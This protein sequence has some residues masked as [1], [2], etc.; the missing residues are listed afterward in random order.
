MA[1]V[2]SIEIGGRFNAAQLQQALDAI[3]DDKL[4]VSVGIKKSELQKSLKDIKD[5]KL[6]VIVQFDPAQIQ[7]ALKDAMGEVSATIPVKVNSSRGG[8]GNAS[9]GSGG[10]SE[11]VLPII[12]ENDL[13]KAG[14]TISK[15]NN[16]LSETER[17]SA[18]IK[19]NA[20]TTT[21]I[22]GRWNDELQEYEQTSERITVNHAKQKELQEK[23]SIEEQKALAKQ[24]AARTKEL[25]ILQRRLGTLREGIKLQ[26][27]YS[28]R[29]VLQAAGLP[30]NATITRN[31]A[32]TPTAQSGTW[33]RYTVSVRNAA[34][35]F[36]TYQIAINQATGAVRVLNQGAF[37][38]NKALAAQGETLDRLIIKVAKWAALTTLVYMPI[39]A[40]KEALTTLKEVDSELVTIQKV[41]DLSE[42]Q[43]KSL[44]STVYGLASAYGR[45]ADELL[46]MTSTFARAGFQAQLEEMTELAALTQNVGD[47]TGEEASQ[48]II[49][50]NAAWKLNGNMD[51][52]M[53]I[54]DGMN[55]VTNHSANDFQ[56]LSQGIS[57]A[58][59]VFANA[60]ESAQTFT[61]ML[62]TVVASTQR[63]GSEV[64]RGLRT[65]AMNIRQIKG[66][67]DDGE[68]IDESTISDA[69]AALSSVGISV[70][71]N[72]QLRRVSDV[73]TDLA[74]KWN[75]LTTAEQSY[76]A[77]SLAGKRQA[78]VLIAL[79][80]N[81]DEY[82]KEMENFA[83][84][85]GSA[86][87]ENEI[88]LDSWDAKTKML[89]ATWTEFVGNL[90]DT[91][92]VKDGL[93]IAIKA[94]DVLNNSFVQT[95]LVVGVAAKAVDLLGGR[96]L[97]LDSI[98]TVLPFLGSVLSGEMTLGAALAGTTA[99][100]L[101]AVAA[102]AGAVALYDKL[103]VTLKE[104]KDVV[105][106]LASE[107]ERM[108]GRG[109][110]LQ[111]LISRESELTDIERR[112]LVYLQAEADAA[113][114][115]LDAERAT[116]VQMARNEF[117][118]F[119]YDTFNENGELTTVD[120]TKAEGEARRLQKA[121]HDLT[122][123]YNSGGLALDEYRVE[124]A[125]LVTAGEETYDWVNALETPLTEGEAAWSLWYGVIRGVYEALLNTDK[126][127]PQ[128][129]NDVDELS[130]KIERL[131]DRY[132]DLKAKTDP[133]TQAQTELN[134][135]GFISVDTFDR[136]AEAYPDI[137][138]SSTAL[139]NGYKVEDGALGNLISAQET[140]S[141]VLLYQ[142]RT[143]AMQFINARAGMAVATNASTK[144]I[145]DHIEALEVEARIA[146]EVNAKS[147]E[148]YNRYLAN[149]KLY[150]QARSLKE[151][152]T[153]AEQITALINS[154]SSK[155]SSS[156][157]SSSKN[158]VLNGINDYYDI[159]KHRIW[160]SE[161]R[162]G[163]DVSA[164]KYQRELKQQA[165]YYVGLKKWSHDEAEKLRKQGYA[166]ESDEIKKLQ[167]IWWEAENWLRDQAKQTAEERKKAIDDVLSTLKDNLDNDKNGLDAQIKKLEALI[168][169]QE[170]Y[171][172]TLT[173]V[174]KE[175]A[176]ID[177][178]LKSAKESYQYLDEATRKMLFNESDY[179]VL[180]AKLTDISNEA[181]AIYENYQASINA[182]TEDNIYLA[183]QLTHEFEQQ[184]EA[185][186]KEY[187]IAKAELAMAKAQTGLQNAQANRNTFMLVDGQ[188]QWVADPKAIKDALENYADA[189][190]EYNEAIK[191]AS[192]ERIKNELEDSKQNLAT[193][194]A[195]LE[196]QYEAIERA[197]KTITNSMTENAV[198]ISNVLLEIAQDATPELRR[199]IEAFALM[200]SQVTGESY[201]I[202]GGTTTTKRDPITVQSINGQAPAGLQV[203]DYVQTNG[204]LW[205]IV[206]PNT[207]GANYNPTTGYWSVKVNNSTKS[208]GSYDD[209]G[210]ALGKGLLLKDTAMAEGVIK[211]EVMRDVLNPTKNRLF[212]SFVANVSTLLNG[213][214]LRQA[215]FKGLGGMV[216]DHSITVNG[217]TVN[218]QAAERLAKAMK[219][220]MPLYS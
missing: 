174:E 107:Y 128:T 58:G 99:P 2:Y 51:S 101:A 116:Y 56:A 37:Q 41:T 133:V 88:Y 113:K 168:S 172:D 200:L 96:L 186:R 21:N 20:Y 205:K 98:G 73:L 118:S 201:S 65:I 10:D 111:D 18:K 211:P 40:F 35:A 204:G 87:R 3:K 160:L 146:A 143:V 110:E 178:E 127:V 114:A 97:A 161:Q 162:M 210:V 91:R 123:Q 196:A 74:D 30:S 155:T 191:D 39:R 140:E 68:I 86:M 194:K 125:K 63:S 141:N 53:S 44:T 17:I 112:R 132:T 119:G 19:E 55:E 52:L 34:G 203:G 215:T 105:T 93:D 82:Y 36:D 104:Q 182:L 45:T 6:P 83:N 206:E 12:N 27:G 183:E 129:G 188:F 181:G 77:S 109:S 61:A 46:E 151:M 218:G 11:K 92:L 49:A 89:K 69:A 67:L 42:A 122:T 152:L 90:V 47:L 4:K 184:Y 157:S 32:L 198:D 145:L 136:L 130:S 173:E 207:P 214:V 62:G 103:N 66:E 94:V 189:E 126:A 156:S 139:A 144:A 165:D 33:D 100:L 31:G 134:E 108:Y 135:Q 171:Y 131:T 48:F 57:V 150:Q 149:D 175:Q 176:E 137:I 166:D 28:E 138:K 197:W 38:T 9:S 117:N 79:M 25:E 169:L 220:V 212:E 43:I 24:E 71:E 177:K 78:N 50:A 158:T 185:K 80:Q 5:A 179:A 60:G 54:I 148:D 187:E 193:E 8:T 154:G 199:Q 29:D 202:N 14:A 147:L 26:G 75:D 209:G 142:A 106:D 213:D 102:I 208:G 76:V 13:Q 15:T 167:Q 217:M 59:S 23:A 121:Y 7:R 70:S 16:L 153:S 1:N 164:E 195:R 124:L 72:G 216:D 159:I 120:M 163:D 85:A 170:S 192:R 22:Q 115:E 81:Y 190:Q 84:G 180:S 95:A 219:A 64:A